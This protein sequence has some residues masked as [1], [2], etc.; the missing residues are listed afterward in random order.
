MRVGDFS[1]RIEE[2]G[3]SYIVY[4]EGITKAR[5]SGLQQKNQKQ[6][7]VTYTK[8]VGYSYQKYLKNSLKGVL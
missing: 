1:F 7:K 8:K 5:Q 3:A 2:S 6:G 4:V